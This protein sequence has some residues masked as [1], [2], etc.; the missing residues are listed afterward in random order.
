MLKGI[1]A[2]ELPGS[3][4]ATDLRGAWESTRSVRLVQCDDRES[5]GGALLL[6]PS[7]SKC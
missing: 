6:P 5:C 7:E 4:A 1:A 3:Q 2:A